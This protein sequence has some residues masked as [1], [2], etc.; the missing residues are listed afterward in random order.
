M[1]NKIT[2]TCLI[3]LFPC[4]Y[5]DPWDAS[6]FKFFAFYHFFI[7]VVLYTVFD[8]VVC[9]SDNC[10]W[11]LHYTKI[12]PLKWVPC[13]FCF[14]IFS[15]A[16]WAD[17]FFSDAMFLF[18]L[19]VLPLHLLEFLGYKAWFAHTQIGSHIPVTYIGIKKMYLLAKG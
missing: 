10:L 6:Y 7:F 14:F 17:F 9:F 8:N 1:I 5:L 16:M 12:L 11:E 4:C 18:C 19:F 3:T 13:G 15:D 2:C